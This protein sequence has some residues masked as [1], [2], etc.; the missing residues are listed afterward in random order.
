M[1]C[2]NVYPTYMGGCKNCTQLQIQALKVITGEAIMH[3]R[4]NLAQT[5]GSTGM[6]K[7]HLLY[8]YPPIYTGRQPEKIT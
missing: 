5:K 3:P 7:E 6:R 2:F 8:C 1:K 4:G